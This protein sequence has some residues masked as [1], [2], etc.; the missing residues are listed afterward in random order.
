MTETLS[1]SLSQALGSKDTGCS[2]TVSSLDEGKQDEMKAQDKADRAATVISA[3]LISVLHRQSV[4]NKEFPASDER[5]DR[6]QTYHKTLQL[7]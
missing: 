1:Q 7:P 2:E 4:S 6:D 3:I 5:F